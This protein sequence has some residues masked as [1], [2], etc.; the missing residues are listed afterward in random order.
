MQDLYRKER[1]EL[2]MSGGGVLALPADDV[3]VLFFE[4]LGFVTDAEDSVA[5]VY[6]SVFEQDGM[7]SFSDR[8]VDVN[9]PAPWSSRSSRATAVSTT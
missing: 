1:A 2:G 8:N 3:A 7:Q 9:N 4:S 5:M 6:G